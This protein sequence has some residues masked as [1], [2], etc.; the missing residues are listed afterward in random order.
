MI[1]SNPVHQN[2]IHKTGD[3]STI[4]FNSNK[5]RGKK[6]TDFLLAENAFKTICG[7][8]HPRNIHAKIVQSAT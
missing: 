3:F 8:N 6:L 1:V 4:N 2:S 5:C 7:D